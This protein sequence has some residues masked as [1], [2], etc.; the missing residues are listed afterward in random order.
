MKNIFTLIILAFSFFANAQVICGTAGEGGVVTLTAPAGNVITSIEFASYGTPDG[1]C[2][3]FTLGACHAAN[4]Q[5]ICEG[6]FVGQNSASINASNG[7]FGD[8]CG[9]TVKR[10]YIQATYSST[11]P[12]TLISFTAKKIDGGKVKL[13][14][15]SDNEINT[16]HFIIERSNDGV[17]FEAEGSVPAT[18]IGRNNYSF[19]NIIPGIV[20][21]YY[22][23]LKMVDRDGKYYY[24]NIVR[25]NNN[26]T[27]I[28]LSV[29]PN[30]ANALITIISNKQQE[31]FI[32]NTTGQRIKK[33][34]LINGNQTLN[35]AAWNPG[36][37]IIKT[38][39]GFMKFIKM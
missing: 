38:E 15:L 11:L 36:I 27:G 8:P 7:V 17:L 24:S 30:P 6:V 35:V 16:S 13:D 23:R 22:Y 26:F 10:L 2:G 32:T 31:A 18:G 9:G 34:N 20:P 37:Y 39:E 28:K 1:V 4:S 21:T 14:W 19:T 3:S 12:L 5:T 29:F 33:I 25:I